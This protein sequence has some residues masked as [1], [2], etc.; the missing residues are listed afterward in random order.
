MDYAVRKHGTPQK[1]ILETHLRK[2]SSGN[3]H[4]TEGYINMIKALAALAPYEVVTARELQMGYEEDKGEQIGELDNGSKVFEYIAPPEL[5]E[6]LFVLRF[7]KTCGLKPDE[8][9]DRLLKIPGIRILSVELP[10]NEPKTQNGKGSRASHAE[11]IVEERTPRKNGNGASDAN[12]DAEIK[13]K[14]RRRQVPIRDMSRFQEL[15]RG[16]ELHR[17]GM[18]EV[19]K[20]KVDADDAVVVGKPGDSIVFWSSHDPS[21]VLNPAYHVREKTEDAGGRSK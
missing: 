18:E 2:P 20:G 7:N 17:Q 9:Q 15:R 10:I 1:V 14:P 4:Y 11:S 16:K 6:D 21:E 8:I 13:T 12:A 5:S 3:G 19:V